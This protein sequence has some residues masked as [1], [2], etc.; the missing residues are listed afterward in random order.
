MG[1]EE[2]RAPRR[3]IRLTPALFKAADAGPV[4]LTEE[5]PLALTEARGV[6]RMALHPPVPPA[7][8]AVRPGCLVRTRDGRTCAVHPSPRP[9]SG[10]TAEAGALDAWPYVS[11]SPDGAAVDVALGR[12]NRFDRLLFYVDV[13]QGATGLRELPAEAAFTAGPGRAWRV[14]LDPARATAHAPVGACAVAL[15]V[16]RPD[17]LELRREVRWYRAGWRTSCR[18]L[19]A[20]DYLG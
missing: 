2:G 16:P 10:P 9:A 11:L 7:E 3:A 5:A 18:R 13:A 17:G 19:L 4:T 12:G 20:R 8:A 1:G 15:L 6:L 14:P